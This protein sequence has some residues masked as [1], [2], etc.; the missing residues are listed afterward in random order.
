[1]GSGALVVCL[2]SISEWDKIVVSAVRLDAAGAFIDVQQISG[3][4]VSPNEKKYTVPG[5]FG[6]DYKSAVMVIT[7]I[8]NAGP[9]AHE[10][11]VTYEIKALVQ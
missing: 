10:Y 3:V 1:L 11:N 6:T 7:N 4:T 5:T 8:K 9:L 2:K